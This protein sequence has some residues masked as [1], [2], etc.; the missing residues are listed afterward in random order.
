MDGYGEFLKLDFRGEAFNVFNRVQFGALG[1]NLNSLNLNS[2][3]F[4]Q[5]TGQANSPRTMQVALKIYW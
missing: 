5:I 2:L 4:G 3:N 1:N